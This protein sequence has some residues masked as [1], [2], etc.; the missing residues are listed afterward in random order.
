M[1]ADHHAIGGYFSRCPIDEIVESEVFSKIEED[2]GDD[3]AIG[4]VYM[5]IRRGQNVIKSIQEIPRPPALS[6]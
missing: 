3:E 2:S 1:N 5:V 4:E 6:L